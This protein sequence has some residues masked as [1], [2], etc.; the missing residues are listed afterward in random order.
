MIISLTL[1]KQL[2][3]RTIWL[4]VLLFLIVTLSAC[5]IQPSRQANNGAQAQ[6]TL[7]PTSV[8]AAKSTYTVKS[9]AVVYEVDFNG[10][11]AP[12]IEETLSFPTDG[13]VTAVH[14][15]RDDSVEVGDPIADL[16][17]Q[18]ITEALTQ[19]QTELKIA[20][21]RLESTTA[22]IERDQN[23]AAIQLEIAQLNLD[24]A[25]NNAGAN[26]TEDEQ[27]GIKM[28]ELQLALKQLDFDELNNDI[29]PVLQADVDAAALKVTQ[30][31]ELL[32][33]AALTAPFA[34]RISALTAVPGFAVSAF[35]PI[36]VVVD[37]TQIEISAN[38]RDNQ[39]EELAE[40]MPVS[41]SLS[42]RPGAAYP[43]TITRLPPPFG[44][45]GSNANLTETDST[46]RFTFDNPDDAEQFELGDRV[47]ISVVVEAKDD[48]LFLPT[49]A[50]RD[51]NGRK[52]VIIQEDG[53]QQRVDVALG[54]SG[55]NIVEIVDGL[56]AGQ[57]IVG[58]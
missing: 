29:D 50:I 20:Q 28:L 15:K 6:P 43:A 22:Q 10:R 51:F 32:A 33:G 5:S 13:V 9:G 39:M 54:I 30:F 4:A 48:V 56:S 42:N 21:A 2:P 37:T 45:G 53:I 18:A 27:F 36:G 58:Q 19:A 8:A 38:L 14:V 24:H 46:T 7:V 12:V 47:K 1:F 57:V 25:I 41:V 3:I 26:P 40:G 55:K 49:A 52:F 17:T 34:G 35:D 31:E 16:D 11:I 44:S 23:R